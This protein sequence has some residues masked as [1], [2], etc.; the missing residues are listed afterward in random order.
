MAAKAALEQRAAAKAGVPEPP[1]EASGTREDSA[2]APTNAKAWHAAA[3]ASLQAGATAGAKAAWISALTFPIDDLA[4]LDAIAQGLRGLDCDPLAYADTVR[5]IHGQDESSAW[6]TA[7]LAALRQDWKAAL[8]ALQNALDDRPASSRRACNLAYAL[9]QLGQEARGQCLIAAAA[10]A[11]GNYR[12]AADAFG[13]APPEAVQTPEYLALAIDALRRVGEE[14]QALRLAESAAALGRCD[15]AARLQWANA[16]TDLHRNEEALAVLRAGA[17]ETGHWKLK[18][19]SELHLPQVPASCEE[20]NLADARACRTIQTLETMEL[21]RDAAALAD[22]YSALEPNFYLGYRDTPNVEAIQRFGRFVSR[23]ATARFPQYSRPPPRRRRNGD[24]LRIGYTTPYF[25]NHTITR[26]FG[27]WLERADRHAFEIH[28]FP[29]AAH[30]DEMLAYLSA[31]VDHVHPAASEL[32]AIAQTI[33]AAD[34]DLLMYLSIGMDPLSMQLG[35]LHLAPV[36]CVGW[37]HPISTGLDALDYFISVD[38]MEPADGN[39]H[40]NERL[41]TLPGTG[42]AIAHPPAPE[43]PKTRAE[44][45]LPEHGLV[46][47]SVQSPFKYLPQYDGLYARIASKLPQAT[48]V[49]VEGDM[50]A[51]TRTF[52]TRIHASFEAAGLPPEKHLHFL[53]Q[54]SFDSWL[55]LLRCGDVALDT[56]D[57]SG[58]QTSYDALSCDLPIVTLPGRM[59]RGRQTCGMLK[60]IGVEDTIASDSEDYVR[61]AVRLGQDRAWRDDIS[62]RIRENKHKLFND[63]HP[64]RALEAFYRWAVGAPKQG[65]TDLFKLWP[66]GSA[67]PTQ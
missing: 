46:F 27:G 3:L 11:S 48:F 54:L 41:V 65:D 5:C 2:S 59:M 1:S 22:L 40:Y 53:P 13:T 33:R 9:R 37:G 44:F 47:L 12:Q 45:G 21:P 63:P 67:E 20:I 23:V 28:M 36:Q 55:S 64:V 4:L 60:H 38:A 31:Q 15:D 7:C 57:F 8:P 58:G 34:L 32:E 42:L 14:T 51:W 30:R 39:C 26:H 56:L 50:P 25:T 18:L 35:A 43:N 52:R 6:Q 66:S 61:I 29:L 49:F 16:L 62:R 19:Q 10:H 24:R 17:A